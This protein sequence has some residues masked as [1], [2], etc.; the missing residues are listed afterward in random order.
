MDLVALLATLRAMGAESVWLYGSVATGRARED[1]DLDLFVV[2]PPG[3]QGA[4]DR[5]FAL[6]YPTVMVD[7]VPR[8]AHILTATVTQTN[9]PA[10]FCRLQ[11]ETLQ[12]NADA[13]RQKPMTRYYTL[14]DGPYDEERGD[15]VLVYTEVDA[16]PD[17]YEW[18]MPIQERIDYFTEAMREF[19]AP[20]TEDLALLEALPRDAMLYGQCG[21]SAL[22]LEA[23]VR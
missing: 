14:T 10:V 13:T 15:F 18:S 6:D 20:L 17:E 22:R 5:R 3:V 2:A 4:I 9:D 1:S 23:E 11:P 21:S 8:E 16:P 7:G 12:L 19:D